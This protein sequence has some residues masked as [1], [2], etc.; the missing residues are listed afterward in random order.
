[1]E[2]EIQQFECAKRTALHHSGPIGTVRPEIYLFTFVRC[3]SVGLS[4]FTLSQNLFFLFFF[5]F[6]SELL[7]GGGHTPNAT[8]LFIFFLFGVRLSGVLAQRI[9]FALFPQLR[10]RGLLYRQQQG[11]KLAGVQI[12]AYCLAQ[13]HSVLHGSTIGLCK[14]IC[15]HCTESA[16]A[17][18]ESGA[19][20]FCE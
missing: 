1:M 6:S 15:G 13:L 4:F 17:A 20:I 11:V 10:N 9:V 8:L 19:C 2:E 3:R 7:G 18:R 5:V 16:K 14:H 12:T